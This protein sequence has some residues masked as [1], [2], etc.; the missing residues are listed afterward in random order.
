MLTNLFYIKTWLSEYLVNDIIK[1]IQYNYYKIYISYI[2]KKDVIRILGEYFKYEK[3]NDKYFITQHKTIT[4]DYFKREHFYLGYRWHDELSWCGRLSI[5]EYI[6]LS[7]KTIKGKECIVI[8][9]S[10]HYYTPNFKRIESRMMENSK[11][12]KIKSK[13]HDIILCYDI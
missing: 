6:T 9:H 13:K 7:H 3:V 1:I 5:D 8:K 10:H 4:H 2:L 12:K 11:Y